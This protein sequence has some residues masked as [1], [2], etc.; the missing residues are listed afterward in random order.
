[1]GKVRQRPKFVTR[2]TLQVKRIMKITV[3]RPGHK[4]YVISYQLRLPMRCVSRFTFH[5]FRGVLLC[6]N[7]FPAAAR[8]RAGRA[9]EGMVVADGA[10]ERNAIHLI[11]DIFC[12]CV[13][14]KSA[15]RIGP[16]V[17]QSLPAFIDPGAGAESNVA[18][19]SGHEKVIIQN[20]RVRTIG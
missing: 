20:S 12:Q 2:E 10:K 16:L 13:L 7:G 5:G 19:V 6:R 15:I 9:I 17:D 14:A 8:V 11:A 18:E 1:M 4:L 3:S